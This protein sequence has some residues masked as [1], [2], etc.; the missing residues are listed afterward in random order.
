MLG[1]FEK[2]LLGVFVVLMFA[3]LTRSASGQVAPSDSAPTPIPVVATYPDD[4]RL[5]VALTM[6]K[7]SAFDAAAMTANAVLVSKPECDR[8]ALI[9][10]IAHTKAKR[11]QEAKPALIRA[12]DSKQPFP[13]RKHAAHF[14]GWCCFHLGEMTEAKA[15][16]EAH[17]ALTPNEPDST[18][19]LGLVAFAEDRLEDADLLYAKALDGFTKPTPKP[20]DQARVLVRMADLALRR[21]DVAGAEKLLDSA[22]KAHALQH[23]TWSK[24]ARVYDRQGKSKEA[25]AARANE[26]RILEALGRRTAQQPVVDTPKDAST[27][28]SPAPKDPA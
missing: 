14:L 26:Q 4:E 11:Y 15:A 2:P 27:A 9:L 18:F 23:E 7:K 19:G 12:R 28:P 1:V 24:L 6:L 5:A 3:A 16:F 8:A 13:E 22:V 25:D 20:Q 17:L 10:G 21:D